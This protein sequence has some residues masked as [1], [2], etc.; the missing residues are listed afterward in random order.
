MTT[1]QMINTLE[2]DG[3]RSIVVPSRT[4]GVANFV[5]VNKT[6]A[7]SVILSETELRGFEELAGQVHIRAYE[8]T[9]QKHEAVSKLSKDRKASWSST[10]E[11]N[12]IR[13]MEARE[14]RL[15]N[16][17]RRQLVIDGEEAAFREDQRHRT[18]TNAVE[19]LAKRDERMRNAYTQMLLQ[20]TLDEQQAQIAA[21]AA[22]ADRMLL[23]KQKEAA[24]ARKVAEQEI[25]ENKLNS[26]RTREDVIRTKMANLAQLEDQISERRAAREEACIEST[27]NK[28]LATAEELS[29][30]LEQS[31]EKLEKTR[32]AAEQNHILYKSPREILQEKRLAATIDPSIAESQAYVDSRD[33][34]MKKVAD[35]RAAKTERQQH[36][37]KLAS[38][39]LAKALEASTAGGSP[40]A[41]DSEGAA[42]PRSFLQQMEEDNLRIE[43]AH[44]K[45]PHDF[46]QAL[47]LSN[48]EQARRRQHQ[49]DQ[50]YNER[51]RYLQDVEHRLN[52]DQSKQRKDELRMEQQ[53]LLL[54][55]AQKKATSDMLKREE[56]EMAEQWA[57]AQ[58]AERAMFKDLI[59]LQMPSSISPRLRQ[60]ALANVLP[61]ALSPQRIPASPRK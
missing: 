37:A 42:S 25:Q 49:A 56:R 20:Q 8:A 18:V 28:L 54:Q 34:F 36:R 2:L 13:A 21:K 12:R 48:R 10:V 9:V 11:G 45:P 38:D 58:E 19:Q 14:Q 22:V 35:E 47:P 5:A 16:D 15:A 33:E 60:R 27:K 17:E 30:K 46:S 29:D 31:H 32:K 57:H 52:S 44:K 55:T 61:S 4:V 23:V 1:Q 24:W 40:Q 59:E 53:V 7:S 39:N 6:I 26:A 50:L 43:A 51:M 3:H 41:K